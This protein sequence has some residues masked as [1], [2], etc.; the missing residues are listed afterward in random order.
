ME[1]NMMGSGIKIKCMEM[2]L[3]LDLM[4]HPTKDNIIK[5]RSMEK[6]DLSGKM[7]TFIM[8]N[9]FKTPFLDLEFMNELLKNMK[10]NG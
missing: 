1:L 4:A 6:E 3:K 9:F 5:E 8:V 2:E 7:D 10:V